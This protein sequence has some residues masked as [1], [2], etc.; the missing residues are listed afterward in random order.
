[1]RPSQK[2]RHSNPQREGPTAHPCTDAGGPPGTG[3]SYSL[4]LATIILR[5]GRAVKT[6][7]EGPCD[8]IF[9]PAVYVRVHERGPFSLRVKEVVHL[10]TK[11]TK[12][13][14]PTH[15][16]GSEESV[17]S[18]ALFPRFLFRGPLP[19][20]AR[21]LYALLL[22]RL[23]LSQHNGWRDAAGEVYL[24]YPID[25]LAQTLGCDPKTVSRAMKA[26]EEAELLVRVR[27]GF[28]RPNRIYL[29]VPDQVEPIE[30]VPEW[31]GKNAQTGS[32]DT[33]RTGSGIS[34]LPSDDL[35][36]ID[37]AKCPSS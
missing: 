30:G 3:G 32:G 31:R 27:T 4:L 34:V 11:K 16:I 8:T 10:A 33:D 29:L 26:L 25:E 1:M 6:R 20:T 28:D 5:P 21:V 13:L 18:Y 19:M 22:D 17:P 2:S 37:R 14:G 12:P 36:L 15:R 23:R 7:F 9:F 24:I 35:A